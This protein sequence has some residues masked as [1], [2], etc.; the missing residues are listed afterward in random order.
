MT[1]KRTLTI[2]ILVTLI[3]GLPACRQQFKQT[4]I[5]PEQIPLAMREEFARSE[6]RELVWRAFYEQDGYEIAVA[7]YAKGDAREISSQQQWTWLVFEGGR[8]VTVPGFSA[9]LSFGLGKDS[10]SYVPAAPYNWEPQVRLTLNSKSGQNTVSIWAVGYGWIP[11]A[12]RVVGTTFRGRS[13]EAPVV[14]GYWILFDLD[15]EGSDQA[16]RFETVD[17]LD[18]KGRVLHAYRRT[19]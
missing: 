5:A 6:I 15:V 2:V 9:K 10:M 7:S 13:F 16:D 14:N 4:A 1:L 19:D 3:A 12:H 8:Q 11:D 18:A 17:L